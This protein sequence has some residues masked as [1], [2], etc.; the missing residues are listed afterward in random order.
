[1]T[2]R[3][4]V[5]RKTMAKQSSLRPRTKPGQARLSKPLPRRLADEEAASEY[6]SAPQPAQARPDHMRLAEEVARLVTELAGVRQRVAELE[7]CADIDPLT[8]IFNRRGFERELKRAVSYVQRYG[9]S[10]A[11]VYLDLDGFKPVNDR[12]GHAA[13]DTVLKAVAVALTRHVRGSDTVARV[14]GDEFTA[15]LW[16]LSESAAFAKAAALEAAI[17]S[18]SVTIGQGAVSVGASAGVAM[19]DRDAL[20]ADMLT[21]ADAAMYARKAERKGMR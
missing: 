17:S 3:A 21:R 6:K 13:G 20:V 5:G 4:K 2:V 15:L 8:G 12:F 11:L 14:G 7:A 1:M 19:F 10:A 16:N 18:V 9:G